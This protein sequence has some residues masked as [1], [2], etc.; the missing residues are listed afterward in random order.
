[1]CYFYGRLM[2]FK[3]NSTPHFNSFVRYFKLKNPAFWLL[4]GFS[5]NNS[6]TRFFP[7]VVFLESYMNISTFIFK[8]KNYTWMDQIIVKKYRVPDTTNF[9]EYKSFLGKANG[10]SQFWEWLCWNYFSSENTQVILNHLY[11]SLEKF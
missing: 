2:T 9:Q 3:K 6:R 5:E 4:W 11:S 1:M 10:D 7:H 8:L